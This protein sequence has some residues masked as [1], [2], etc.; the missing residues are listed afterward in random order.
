MQSEK[1]GEYKGI[2]PDS[3]EP[4]L[5]PPAHQFSLTAP[6]LDLDFYI[7]PTPKLGLLII[8]VT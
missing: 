6:T 7:L 5:Y 3:A 8:F 4:A 2:R 1:T